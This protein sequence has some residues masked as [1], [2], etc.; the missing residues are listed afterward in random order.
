MLRALSL[1]VPSVICLAAASI[2]A[3]SAA[4]RT[5]LRALSLNEQKCLRGGQTQCWYNKNTG[6]VI[7]YGCEWNQN[8]CS[9]DPMGGGGRLCD[10][11]TAPYNQ[12]TSYET[13]G[14]DWPPYGDPPHEAGSTND[15]DVTGIAVCW[16]VHTCAPCLFDAGIPRWI[17]QKG[18]F[19]NTDML[20]DKKRQSGTVCEDEP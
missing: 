19:Q 8:T 2:V 3:A 7:V 10:V 16:L 6:C 12:D 20:M 11:L 9:P 15:F 5:D 14:A 17:C 18:D 4:F 1:F 13:V